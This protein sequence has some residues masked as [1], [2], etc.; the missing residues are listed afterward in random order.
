MTKNRDD[1]Q[2]ST[3]DALGKRSAFICSYSK[4]RCNTLSPS[5]EDD[6]KF[7]YI[8][9]AAH[10]TAAAKGGA[11]Y[12]ERMSSEQR[13][14]I[15]NAIFLCSNCADMIDKNK[16]VD[17]PVELLNEWKRQHESWVHEN[18]GL[19]NNNSSTTVNVT[20]NNQSG[21]ITAAIVN[22]VNSQSYQQPSENIVKLVKEG[23]RKF[24][25]S[26][27]ICCP[28]IIIEIELGNSM[29]A[30]VA[31]DL[32]NILQEFDLGYYQ[33]GTYGG[34]FPDHPITFTGN[35]ENITFVK[36]LLNCINPYIKAECSYKECGT[37][38][39]IFL[40]ING[41]PSFQLDGSVKIE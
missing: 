29:R 9:K 3:V 10:I 25:N 39:D 5:L 22:V 14:S 38:D 35:R 21:G 8:G 18:I 33:Q 12:D 1:F 28:K 2:K 19:R 4:C 6:S 30:K 37:T 16:G 24:K 15:E 7:I 17:F 31:K 32:E 26:Y 34:R 40:Y 20:S 11:R 13:K 36:E 23:L 41:T 27:G